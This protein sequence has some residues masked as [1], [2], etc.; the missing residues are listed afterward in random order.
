M[1]RLSKR[2][3][4]LDLCSRREADRLIAA[5]K[6]AVGGTNIGSTLGFKVPVDEADIVIV[7][8]T[9]DDASSDDGGKEAA[10][11]GTFDWSRM[12]GDVVVLHK[13]VGYVSGQPEHPAVQIPAVR[14]LSRSK[15]HLLRG[16]G[17]DATEDE[18]LSAMLRSGNAFHF[19]RRFGMQMQ[20]GRDRPRGNN[21]DGQFVRKGERK[22]SGENDESLDTDRDEDEERAAPLPQLEATLSGYVPAGRLDQATS[23][24]LLFTRSGVFAKKLVAANSALDKEYIVRV[25]PAQHLSRLEIRNGMRA[26]P[27]PNRNLHPLVKGGRKLHGDDRPLK[28]L[29]EAEWLE[30]ADLRNPMAPPGVLRLVLREGRKHQVRR[31]CRELLGFHCVALE[32]TRVA[33][34][35]LD[36]LP[37]GTW[38]PL[39]EEEA[40]G[41]FIAG[42][43]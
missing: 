14:L 40:R 3:S 23:G 9:G 34:V 28:P 26:L 36:G 4:E 10:A 2:M 37:E 13:P 18:E 30:P 19:V 20:R 11:A 6:V 8:N 16:E 12:M 32:R 35:T 5:G 25:T 22:E 33:G 24:L 21:R 29:R 42:K 1:V 41:I 27:R 7:E 31:M 17:E 39:R 43:K 15:L 38:R